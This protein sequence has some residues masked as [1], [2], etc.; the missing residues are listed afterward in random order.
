MDHFILAL[1]IA[2]L[3]CLLTESV[4]FMDLSLIT[5]IFTYLYR[6]PKHLLLTVI[7]YLGHFWSFKTYWVL[8]VCFSF[9]SPC[10]PQPN[11]SLVY[12]TRRETVDH[13]LHHFGHLCLTKYLKSCRKHRIKHYNP[14]QQ[15]IL[16]IAK[17]KQQ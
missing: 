6:S 13:R 11:L 14:S 3:T 17:N 2:A 4:D 16:G 8:F 15:S 1:L 9:T 12:T 10:N 5:H 7:P